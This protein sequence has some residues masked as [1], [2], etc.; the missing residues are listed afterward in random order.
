MVKNFLP[1]MITGI[2]IASLD[3][4]KIV[5]YITV[6]NVVIIILVNIG[7]ILGSLIFGKLLGFYPAEAMIVIGCNM[8][9]LGGSGALQVLSS[10]DR[11][12]M[13]P[14]A[15]IANRIG[16]AVNIILISL[17]IFKVI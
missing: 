4:A 16:G 5:E 12:E 9:N 3:L 14:F 13:M 2:G 10:T 6:T 11:M 7:S 1:F 8:G 15:V 17:L